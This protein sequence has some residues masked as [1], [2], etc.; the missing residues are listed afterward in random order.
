[1]TLKDELILAIFPTVI[2]LA[3]LLLVEFL[4]RQRLLFASLASS[5]FLIYL[6]PA[7]TANSVRSLVISQLTAATAGL[8]LYLLLGG[9]YL[10]GGLAMLVTILLMIVFNANHPP[11]VATSLGFAFRTGE[12]KNIGIFAMAVMILAILVVIQRT[13]LWLLEKRKKRQNRQQNP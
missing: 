8:L 4:S 10:S 13:A 5:A 7:H 3:V 2:V 12:V 9:H 6:D 11:A 1:M